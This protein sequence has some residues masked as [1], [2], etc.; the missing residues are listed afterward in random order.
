VSTPPTSP[1]PVSGRQILV[2]G[3]P[4]E[5]TSWL[6]SQLGEVTVIAGQLDDKALDA[7]R[8]AVFSLLV[9]N[10]RSTDEGLAAFLRWTRTAA[11]LSTA[12]V[13]FCLDREV[14]TELAEHIVG[15]LAAAKLL[16]H[17]IDREELVREVGASLGIS[18]PT[19]SFPGFHIE[20][21][22]EAALAAIWEEY[23]DTM[24]G[25][26]DLIDQ[27][28]ASIEA[29][30]PSEELIRSAVV[31]AHKLAGTIGTGGL[32]EGSRQARELEG[33]LRRSNSLSR[34]EM[35]HLGQLARRLREELARTPATPAEVSLIADEVLANR[36][37]QILMVDDD[38]NLGESLAIEAASRGMNLTITTSIPS[39]REYL[40]RQSP[41]VVLLDLL[42]PDGMADSMAFLGELT[43]LEQPIPVL[44]LTG[45]DTFTDRVDVAR[46]GGSGFLQKPLPPP[47]VIDAVANVL[48]RVSAAEA[49]VLAVDDDP[50]I[51]ATLRALLATPKV[52]V[53][54]QSDPLK[55]WETLEEVAP[56][57]LVLDVDMPQLSG[58]ELCR[59]V[60]NDPRWA[61]LPVVFLTALS[62]AQT[63]HRLFAAG[64]D[65]YV[66]KPI[67]GPELV[68]RIRNRLDRTQLHRNMAE[69]DPL[70]GLPNRRKA[71]VLISQY[72]RQAARNHDHLCLAVIDVDRFKGV[73]DKYGHLAGDTVLSR[74]GQFLLQAF[75]SEDV[76]ARWGGEE[77]LIAMYG[78]TREN[79][80]H[81]L[82]DVLDTV[83]HQE[84]GG[85]GGVTFGVT[86]SGGVAAYPE[87]GG[88]LQL[89]FREADA[90]LYA[91]KTRGRNR[92]ATANRSP[93]REPLQRLDVL[94]IGS[95]A[96]FAQPFILALE[97]RA[98]ETQW[99]RDIDTASAMLG[100]L[101][102]A[103]HPAVIV[104]HASQPGHDELSALER[105][106]GVEHG[107]CRA[108]IVLDPMADPQLSAPVE[109]GLIRR[110][111]R[112]FAIPTL[113]QHIRRALENR[114]AT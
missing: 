1:R 88:T 23:R 99:V 78:S 104:L 37:P 100:Y 30:Q 56:D 42:F 12:P 28:I 68:T 20:P 47:Q 18:A 39:A 86:F 52:R 77:F 105:L 57:L 29:G 45:R 17:P 5:L 69:T 81:R 13:L 67:V 111:A 59:V 72:F 62:D 80:I 60:R 21:D 106:V 91:A 95:D 58:I 65:D 19:R 14:G 8:N 75:R 40:T 10:Y 34:S 32:T 70:T 98:Y 36:P 89:V 92:L 82:A 73:N 63:V 87:D 26:L 49:R 54:T 11:R 15:D 85:D 101:P 109:P 94:G 33:L 51:L 110:I 4:S 76:V 41:D 27:A 61:T 79:G 97:T 3:L 38:R 2:V 84:F 16:F 24:I 107:R 66:I 9:I 44:V 31:E 102:P 35:L 96:D 46:L 53:S 83:R 55:F 71:T 7:I 48:Q 93:E 43:R 112:P 50:Q 113:M 74:M 114:S 64:A 90:A 108:I 6:T 22:L 103:S 25:G